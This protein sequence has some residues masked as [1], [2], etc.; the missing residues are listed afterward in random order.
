MQG[1]GGSA[2]PTL[3]LSTTVNG[4]E[5]SVCFMPGH[6]HAHLTGGW[7]GTRNGIGILEERKISSPARNQTMMPLLSNL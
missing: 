5:W 3:N 4:H 7:V 6:P 1:S 2:P